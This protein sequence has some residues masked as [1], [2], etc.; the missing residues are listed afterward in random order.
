MNRY[1]KMYEMFNKIEDMEGSSDMSSNSRNGESTTIF[2]SPSI[3]IA[4][5][6]THEAACE[7]SQGARWCTG[8]ADKQGSKFFE[9]YD[10]RGPL[11]IVLDKDTGDKFQMHLESKLFLDSKDSPVDAEAFFNEYP[12]ASAA[13]MAFVLDN[14]RPKGHF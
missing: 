4:V 1:V 6:H 14:G 7:L 5:P 10:K 2:D 9:L 12:E 3:S 13:I 11:F 8:L